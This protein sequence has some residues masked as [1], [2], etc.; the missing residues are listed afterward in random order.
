MKYLFPL[1]I[2]HETSLVKITLV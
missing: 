1:T 2:V